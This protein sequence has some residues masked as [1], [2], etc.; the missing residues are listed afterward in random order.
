LIAAIARE[1][2]EIPA[3]IEG[4]RE[5]ITWPPSGSIDSRGA[6]TASVRS[7]PV[8]GTSPVDDDCAQVGAPRIVLATSPAATSDG[9]R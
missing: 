8:V 2:D 4:E 5:A 6:S 1:D 7:R 9:R 3:G